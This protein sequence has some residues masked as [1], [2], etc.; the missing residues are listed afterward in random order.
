M[1][2]IYDLDDVGFVGGQFKKP[3]EDSTFFAAYFAKLKANRVAQ[4]KENQEITSLQ[5][6]TKETI[7][8][9]R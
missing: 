6:W 2:S 5:Q 8:S 7:L 4:G 3:E 9:A 1:A